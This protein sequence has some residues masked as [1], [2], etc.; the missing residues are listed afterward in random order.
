M[1]L[2]LHL[3]RIV[4][5]FGGLRCSLI[6]LTTKDRKL[7]AVTVFGAIAMISN[8]SPTLAFIDAAAS[9]VVDARDK[10]KANKASI[11]TPDPPRVQPVMTNQPSTQKSERALGQA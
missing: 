5:G 9:G 8:V 4:T 2:V 7:L 10:T 6:I 11:L 3:D 1:A